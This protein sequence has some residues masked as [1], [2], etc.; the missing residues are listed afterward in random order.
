MTESHAP[1]T[2]EAWLSAARSADAVAIISWAESGLIAGSSGARSLWHA[3]C[4][5]HDRPRESVLDCAKALAPI[6]QA[7]D[8]SD[9]RHALLRRADDLADFFESIGALPTPECALFCLSQSPWGFGNIPN[10]RLMR[11]LNSGLIDL[12]ASDMDSAPCTAAPW[13]IEF[14]Q[15]VE[16][17]SPEHAPMAFE[18]FRKA[19]AASEHWI[20]SMDLPF[21]TF[22]KP[23]STSAIWA[24]KDTPENRRRQMAI[25]LRNIA[26]SR[27]MD[28]IHA[29]DIHA[30]VCWFQKQI[31]AHETPSPP[32]RENREIRL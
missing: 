29:S 18:S 6:V 15:A 8:S 24:P 7:P 4:D 3:L 26:L 10:E 5:A 19:L 32:L 27:G 11:W 21:D 13:T 12:F 16:L 14:A 17:A 2:P 22:R 28:P 30:L 1:S 20:D 31:L 23:P 9:L 25:S